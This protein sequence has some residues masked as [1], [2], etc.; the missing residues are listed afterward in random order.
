VKGSCRAT[1]LI[2][3]VIVIV[4]TGILAGLGSLIVRQII[5][6]WN[7]VSFRAE[8]VS[9]M[10]G[11][12]V[13]MGRQIRSIKNTTAVYTANATCLRFKTYDNVNVTYNISGSNVLESNNVLATGAARLQFTYYNATG[14]TLANPIVAPLE[15]DIR[16][17]NVDLELRSAGQNKTTGVMVYPRNLGG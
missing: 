13:R 9:Q 1:T 3:L 17:I 4:I 12:L 5:D 7:T 6:S 11:A 10:R 15:T 16:R 2:E 8:T 14:N